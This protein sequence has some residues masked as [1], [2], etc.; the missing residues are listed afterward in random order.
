MLYEIFKD[1]RA[2]RELTEKICREGYREG[3]EKGF[4]EGFQERQLNG[5]RL[6][7][8]DLIGMRFADQALVET[9]R[10]QVYA[11][12]D[13][14]TLRHLAG[15]VATLQQSEDLASLLAQ[16]LEGASPFPISERAARAERSAQNVAD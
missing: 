5:I 1:T 15:K 14:Q 11:I 13:E 9:A 8:L 4:R 6:V 2:L 3:Y 10:P 12:K 16:C 7:V